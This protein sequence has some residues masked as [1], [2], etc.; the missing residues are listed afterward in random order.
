MLAMHN[1]HIMM[2]SAYGVDDIRDF[3]KQ[4]FCVFLP[5]NTYVKSTELQTLYLTSTGNGLQLPANTELNILG[6]QDCL[7]EVSDGQ[8]RIE[9]K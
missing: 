5:V 8:S 3:L 7:L 9:S 4:Y 1:S 6:I 2:G